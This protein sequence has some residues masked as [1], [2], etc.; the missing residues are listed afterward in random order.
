MLGDGS[1]RPL[2]SWK[3][4]DEVSAARWKLPLS[5]LRLGDVGDTMH[6]RSSDRP[7][8]QWRALSSFSQAETLRM[9]SE[10]TFLVLTCNFLSQYKT[11]RAKTTK[12]NKRLKATI[13]L[14]FCSHPLLKFKMN[15]MPPSFVRHQQPPLALHSLVVQDLFTLCQS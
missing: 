14:F 1:L 6:L 11:L 8:L 13:V 9:Q 7:P 3:G 10:S 4:Y 5:G 2:L 12:Q 15:S